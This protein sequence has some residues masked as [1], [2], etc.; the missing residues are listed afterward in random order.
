MATLNNAAYIKQKSSVTCVFGEN[1]SRAVYIAS[2]ES[3]QPDRDLF[4]VGAKL[5]ENIF[6]NNN[7]INSTV[8]TRT[9]GSSTEWI[10]SG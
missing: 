5:T 10:R 9:W 3:C 8:T 6:K 4:G 7:Q 2:S 1:D